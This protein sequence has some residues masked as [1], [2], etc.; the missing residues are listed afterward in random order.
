MTTPPASPRIVAQPSKPQLSTGQKK[1]NT[2]MEK[3]E[4]RRKLL[5]QW[6]SAS[7]TCEQLWAKE[8]VPMFKEQAENDISSCACLTRPSISSA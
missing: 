3:L 4:T 1:F 7:T 8:L 2:L 6:L 5:Q